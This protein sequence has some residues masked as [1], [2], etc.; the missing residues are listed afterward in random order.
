M[1]AMVFMGLSQTG[2]EF[3]P[4]VWIGWPNRLLVLAIA[5]G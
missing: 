2:G 4:G 5:P 1:F 3:G